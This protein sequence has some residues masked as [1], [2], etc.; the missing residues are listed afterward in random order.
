MTFTPKQVLCLIS[1]L[2]LQATM[3]FA[4]PDEAN[5][6]AAAVDARN[7][8]K[9]REFLADG[10]P[11]ELKDAS[12]DELLQVFCAHADE[13]IDEK[14]TSALSP[15][16]E[17]GQVL[18]RLT[19]GHRTKQ[20]QKLHE[21]LVNVYLFFQKTDDVQ[22]ALRH[23]QEA[24]ALAEELK[25]QDSL[26]VPSSLNLLGNA[27]YAQS[28]YQEALTYYERAS[29]L[30]QEK[31]THDEGLLLLAR[32]YHN[33]SV[34][35]LR[36]QGQEELAVT[37][38]LKAL[39]LRKRLLGE[40]HVYVI[41]THNSLGNAYAAMQ[42]PQARS[43]AEEHFI[44][45]QTAVERE[46]SASSRAILTYN[47]LAVFYGETRKISDIKK[48]IQYIE[49]SRNIVS[50]RSGP[51]HPDMARFHH[52]L[53]ALYRLLGEE[54]WPAAIQNLQQALTIRE[55]ALGH[56][57]VFVAN[58]HA[59]LG[60][61]YYDM[62]EKDPWDDN[63][64]QAL[65]KSLEHYKKAHRILT[66]AEEVV[67]HAQID[68]VYKMGSIHYR[69]GNLLTSAKY[70][71]LTLVLIE[72]SYQSYKPSCLDLLGRIQ[73]ALRTQWQ[74]EKPSPQD[75]AAAEQIFKQHLK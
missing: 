58:T 42:T 31:Q 24:L 3:V 59:T 68:A 60:A 5:T 10:K 52:N 20:V 45:A 15:M 50:K 57:H 54:G 63:K 53:A 69:L 55:L 19:Q 65:N 38:L 21:A 67:S 66:E 71:A 16:L 34:S 9:L 39:E 36:L 28:K 12:L 48:A 6:S 62:G 56:N 35:L 26:M 72:D 1:V 70:I 73:E 51:M 8:D 40:N 46:G 75:R 29:A 30:L 23:A 17:H 44:A 32:T 74:E 49:K 13:K 2:L 61:T 41:D 14:D 33:M 43:K 4:S 64:E 7:L 37:H 22:A 18:Y 11:E 25:D 27:L 47:N